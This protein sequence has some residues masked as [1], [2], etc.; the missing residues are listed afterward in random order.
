MTGFVPTQGNEI[1]VEQP[2]SQSASTVA[3]GNALTS[4]LSSKATK[5]RDH[6]NSGYQRRWAEYWRMW[7][8]MWDEAD[9]N[10]MSERSRL[11]APALANAIEMTVAEIE[12]GLFSKET[13]FDIVDDIEDKKRDD[14]LIARDNLRYDLDK[15]NTKDVFSEAVLNSAIFGTGLIK[16][17]VEV[18]SEDKPVR[19]PKTLKL[20]QGAKE[21]VLVTGESIRPDEFI[22]DPAG[23]TIGEMLGCFHEVKKPLNAVLEK[24]QSGV[25][26]ESAL[27]TLHG[28]PTPKSN[29]VDGNDPQAMLLQPV[30]DEVEILEY[31]GKVPA[32]F[33]AMAQGIDTPLDAMLAKDMNSSM[34]GNGPMIEA[35]VTIANGSTLLRAIPNPFVMKDRS[36]IAFQFEKVPGRFWGRSVSEKGYNPQKA[37]DAEVRARIDALG[38]ISSPMLGVD[39]GRIPRGF[40]M[41]IK[42]GKLFLTQGNPDEILRPVKIGEVNPN[43]FN[44]A[45][46][47]ERMVQMGTGAFDT[48]TALTSQGSNSSGPSSSNMSASMGAFVKRSKRSIRNVNDNAISPFI[49]KAMWRYMQ[50]DP[51]RYPEDFDFVVKATMGIVARE[52]EAMQLTQLMAMLPDDVPEIKVAVAKGIIDLSSVHNK[53]EVVAAMNQAMQ[54]PSPEQ[55]QRQQELDDLNFEATKAEATQSLLENQKLIADIRLTLAEAAAMRRKADNEDRKMDQE[56]DRIEIQEAELEGFQKQNDISM[57]RLELQEEQ[58]DIKKQELHKKD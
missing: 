5:W 4:W 6:R 29:E 46:E 55:Q 53:A 58:L 23:R 50:F 28:S 18:V 15:A 41:E 27:A 25:Y 57:K 40:K 39:Y 48:A 51:R 19:N 2:D 49:K 13:W 16:V 56:D 26:L 37:L 33:L 32:E 21:R 8:G 36:I 10:R 9:R 12:E 35:I 31:H 30:T 47:M 1:I 43:T 17:N 34:Q 14:A 3:P 11:I 44:Q 54:P 22:P 52:V 42:P 7:R 38:Y 20:E 24:I 45:G